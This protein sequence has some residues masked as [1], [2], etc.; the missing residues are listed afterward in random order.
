MPK[1]QSSRERRYSDRH[2]K[3]DTTAKIIEKINQDE[4]VRV[5]VEETL[6]MLQRLQKRH[7]EEEKKDIEKMGFV[8]ATSRPD[9]IADR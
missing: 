5:Y 2:P 3:P 9:C 6:P 8:V 4:A 1:G 7:A